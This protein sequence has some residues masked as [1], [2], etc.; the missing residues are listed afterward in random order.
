[1]HRNYVGNVERGEKITS[2]ETLA[3]ISHILGVS[4]AEFFAPFTQKPGKRSM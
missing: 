3:R 1:L 2:I 4:L